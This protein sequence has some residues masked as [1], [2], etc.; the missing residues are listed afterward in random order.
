MKTVATCPKLNEEGD[1]DPKCVEIPLRTPYEG[2]IDWTRM[3][4]TAIQ[5]HY[6]RGD[7]ICRIE[8]KIRGDPRDTWVIQA[9]CDLNIIDIVSSTY[10]F[11][12]DTLFNYVEV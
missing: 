11:E 1:I 6:S 2:I 8:K 9:P 10:A 3:S 4:A 5:G 12:D 7:D